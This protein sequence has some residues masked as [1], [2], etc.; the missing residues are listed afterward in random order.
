MNE[1]GE[2]LAASRE[3]CKFTQRFVAANLGVT[4][5]FVSNLERGV[6]PLP[7]RFVQILCRLYGVTQD[8]VVELAMRRAEATYLKDIG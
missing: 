7:A 3:Q 4:V 8:T 6:T 5:Q 2:F 1:L